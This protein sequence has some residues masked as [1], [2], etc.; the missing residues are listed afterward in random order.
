MG[1]L[2]HIGAIDFRSPFVKYPCTF[3]AAGMRSNPSTNKLFRGDPNDW[4]LLSSMPEPGSDR[5][6]SC[7]DDGNVPCHCHAVCPQRHI[8]GQQ[9][10]FGNV[11]PLI[12][13]QDRFCQPISC[14]TDKSLAP[15]C[16]SIPSTV[17]LIPPV[18]R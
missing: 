5:C 18:C 15:F 6:S 8:P 9:H 14:I 7:G 1:L 13:P 16:F 11:H 10:C 17:A 4:L 2:S 12:R 3:G